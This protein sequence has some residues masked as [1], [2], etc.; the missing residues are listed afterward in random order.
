MAIDMKRKIIK[1]AL[2]NLKTSNLAIFFESLKLYLSLF[3]VGTMFSVIL[4][5]M[6][7]VVRIIII[8]IYSSSTN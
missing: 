2:E 7:L 6:S 1:I 4:C 8:I 3:Y 5:T